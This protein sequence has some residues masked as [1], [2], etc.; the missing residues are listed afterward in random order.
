MFIVFEGVDGAGKSSY[1]QPFKEMLQEVTK[2]NVV[3]TR[4]PGGTP[5]GEAMRQVILSKEHSATAMTELMAMMTIRN[6]HIEQHIKPTLERGDIVLCDR[7]HL[8]TIAFQCIPNN[9][10]P[11]I[12]YMLHEILYGA[13]CYPDLTVIFNTDRDIINQ[14]KSFDKADRFESR[15]S[16]FY[17]QLD[18]FYREA[19]KGNTLDLYKT[20]ATIDNNGTIDQ[21]KD[22]LRNIVLSLSSHLR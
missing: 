7:F 9:I 8:S 17:D 13:D 6:Q 18:S 12:Y 10:D 22:Q 2:K 3:V 20:I 15:D 21:T 16:S 5:F 19:C 11:N 14:R 4:E 1:I